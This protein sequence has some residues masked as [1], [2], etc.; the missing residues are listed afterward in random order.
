MRAAAQVGEVALRVQ[1]DLPLGGARELDLVRLRLRLEAR[2]RLVAAELLARPLASLGD[3]APDLL[4]DGLEIGL[5]DRL[6]E[7]EVVVETVRDRGADRDLHA[8]MQAHDRLGE[9]V[10]GRVPEDEEGIRVVRVAR[11]QEPDAL[12]VRER[13]TQIA[14]RA[15]H[16]DEHGLL[17]E[18]RPDRACGVEAVRAIG[19]LELGGVGKDDLHGE[20]EDRPRSG[21]LEGDAS[22]HL[23]R[24]RCRAAPASRRPPRSSRDRR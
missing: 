20:C 14:R 8:G 18:L 7:L 1:R 13:Q 22:W 10:R 17:G 3:L 4:L 5:G 11:R 16:L 24:R 2:D 23:G 19:E 12:A 21:I 6:R 15:V 9:E